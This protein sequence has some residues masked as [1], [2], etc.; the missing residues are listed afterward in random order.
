MEGSSIKNH[1]EP[2]DIFAESA[3]NHLP[4][5][6]SSSLRFALDER[7]SYTIQDHSRE[8]IAGMVDVSLINDAEILAKHPRPPLKDPRQMGESPKS[9]QHDV[10]P[11]FLDVKSPSF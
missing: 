10:Q 3:R 1:G 7:I 11:Q 8:D 2:L 9:N 4:W 6:K 5:I